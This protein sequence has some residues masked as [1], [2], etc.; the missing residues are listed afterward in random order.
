[1]PSLT[2]SLVL[3]PSVVLVMT[4]FVRATGLS[5][6]QG[7]AGPVWLLIAFAGLAAGR[8]TIVR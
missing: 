2:L 4:V 3:V 5:G 8:S 7:V 6:F 1:M